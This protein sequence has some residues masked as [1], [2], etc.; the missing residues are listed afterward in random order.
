MSS[1]GGSVTQFK[2]H[3]RAGRSSRLLP[4]YPHGKLLLG[5]AKRELAALERL[6]ALSASLPL[7]NDAWRILLRILI[8]TLQRRQ[9][10]VLGLARDLRLSPDI[11]VR[12]IR[13]L[14]S[15]RLV[16]VCAGSDGQSGQSDQSSRSGEGRTN[17]AGQVRGP[18]LADARVTIGDEGILRVARYF[19][20][21]AANE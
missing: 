13:A 9:V 5:R 15:E 19:L 8:D 2:S 17:A 20:P 1:N 4:T 16:L 3:G 14:E 7:A 6:A 11:V 18:R 12:Y 10:T 21:E